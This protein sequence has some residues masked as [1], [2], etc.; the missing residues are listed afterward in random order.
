[1]KN[2]RLTLIF[3][4]LFLFYGCSDSDNNNSPKTD[5]GTTSGSDGG[6]PLSDGNTNATDS[7]KPSLPACGST[8]GTG[9]QVTE[10][11]PA[12]NESRVLRMPI[13]RLTFSDEIC[14]DNSKTAK[15]ALTNMTTGQD[16]PLSEFT[17]DGNPKNFSVKPKQNLDYKAT[18]VL[19]VEKFADM[20]GTIIPACQVTFTVKT[21]TVS[22]RTGDG[23]SLALDEDGTLWGW[24][25]PLSAAVDINP[26]K[27]EGEASIP[28]KIDLGGKVVAMATE[29]SYALAATE[30]GIIWSWGANN[31]G[32]LGDGTKTDAREKPVKVQLTLSS[33]VKIIDLAATQT[34]ALALRNDG[35]V[36]AWGDNGAGQLGDGT[37]TE[38][39]TPL[40]VSDLTDV[41]QIRA[42]TGT[43]GNGA[44]GRWSL[45]LKNDGTA[46]GWGANNAG[47][48]AQ[49][50]TASE[51]M[52]TKPV[53]IAVTNIKA[54]TANYNQGFAIT[55]GGTV[56]AWGHTQSG[57]LGN[58]HCNV[59]EQLVPVLVVS[60]DGN[61][62]LDQVLFIDGGTNYALVARTDGTVWGWG[63]NLQGIL[64]D[65]TTGTTVKCPGGNFDATNTQ[66]VPKQ[67][68]QVSS[69]IMVAAAGSQSLVLL[70]D[71]TV[72]GAGS[73]TNNKI[74]LGEDAKTLGDTAIVATFTP[75]PGL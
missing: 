2:K 33:G 47:Q 17:C 68:L 10:V 63:N 6:I 69:A 74:G 59:G 25:D 20:S 8:T 32:Q 7:Q 15:L 16:I 13:I 27:F 4:L 40:E 35:K 41:I 18:Y 73:N 42:A 75:V 66:I 72:L 71:G 21:K 51:H 38:H 14:C 31:F 26:G 60:Q 34:H 61:G 39:L 36:L 53:K 9:F 23:Y 28:S 48:L 57:A 19:T 55:N 30:D 67:A 52:F 44:N 64:G 46:W 50:M 1:M 65:G 24:G 37:K 58:N 56:Y 5:H 49:D 70:N 3:P 54:I 45:A 22:I 29:G 43:S 11:S 12:N 62:T